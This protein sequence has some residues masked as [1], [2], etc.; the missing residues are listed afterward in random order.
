MLKLVTG[1]IILFFGLGS[2]YYFLNGYGQRPSSIH[3]FWF[4][5]PDEATSLQKY[6]LLM[7]SVLL[8]FAGLLLLFS[9]F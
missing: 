7:Q 4:V 1:L 2:G 6:F 3:M 9:D 8:I 5:K